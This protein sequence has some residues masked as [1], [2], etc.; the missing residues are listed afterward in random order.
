MNAKLALDNPEN[1]LDSLDFSCIMSLEGKHMKTIGNGFKFKLNSQ[2]SA[3]GMM[4]ALGKRLKQLEQGETINPP[5]IISND[6]KKRDLIINWTDDN[7][8]EEKI[9]YKFLLDPK[10]AEKRRWEIVQKIKKEIFPTYLRAW[11]RVKKVKVAYFYR[12]DQKAYA[13]YVYN[14]H[15]AHEGISF[16]WVKNKPKKVKNEAIA[17]EYDKA[18]NRFG[19]WNAKLSFWSDILEHA[20]FS[21]HQRIH[22]KRAGGLTIFDINGRKYMYL[23]N[24][25]GCLDRFAFPS[26]REDEDKQI[27]EVELTDVNF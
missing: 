17:K 16:H 20:I 6:G 5:W 19:K 18:E 21:V 27:E 14:K 26:W 10:A 15:D 7:G 1:K 24:A 25:M 13:K 2:F 4:G 8:H 23:R 22:K 11:N 3:L 12:K 9:K